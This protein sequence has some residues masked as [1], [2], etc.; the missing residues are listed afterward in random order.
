M[1][2]RFYPLRK[3]PEG[4]SMKDPWICPIC[5]GEMIKGREHSQYL[6]CPRG[7]GRLHQA[8]RI[9]DFPLASRAICRNTLSGIGNGVFPHTKLFWISGWPGFWRY[10][11]YA[12]KTAL[13]KRPGPDVVIAGVRTKREGIQARAFRRAGRGRK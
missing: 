11:P 9:E 1:R 2:G 4:N 13:D 8:P 7:H 3:M 10:I 5:N 12:H 6:T